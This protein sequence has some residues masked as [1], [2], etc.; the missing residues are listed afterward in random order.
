MLCIPELPGLHAPHPRSHLHLPPP[1]LLWRG[2]GAGGLGPGHRQPPEEEGS[3]RGRCSH[4]PAPLPPPGP[5]LSPCLQSRESFPS[6]ASPAAHRQG[7]RPAPGGEDT[8]SWLT[9]IHF[10]P[11]KKV[12]HPEGLRPTFPKCSVGSF[13]GTCWVPGGVPGI[14]SRSI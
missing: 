9:G 12:L 11:L 5:T 10:F 14:S 3:C 4:V 2:Q 8:G 1:T 7:F 6:L 13:Q